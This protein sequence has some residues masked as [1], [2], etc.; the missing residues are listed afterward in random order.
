MNKQRAI[1]YFA[2]CFMN[3]LDQ[4]TGKS[5]IRLLERIGYHPI[6]PKQKCCGLPHLANGRMKAFREY[7][8][9]NIRHLL[10]ADCDILTSCTSCAIVLK[11]DYPELI[12]SHEAGQVAQRTHDIID[13]LS[14]MNILDDLS[15]EKGSKTLRAIYHAPCH[16]KASGNAIIHSRMAFLERIPGLRIDRI[17]RGCCGMGGTYGIKG[18]SFTDSMEIGKDLFEGIKDTH[19]DLILTDCPACKMQIEQ[20]TS[21]RVTHP[22]VLIENALR[23]SNQWRREATSEE[24]RSA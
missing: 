13:F 1:A 21:M 10:E 18:S 14:E 4:D 16:L 2:G 15:Q 9:F 5:A 12:G 8:L 3:F 19:A 6:I 7:A 22:V 23:D 24:Q 20:G 11:R 17:D